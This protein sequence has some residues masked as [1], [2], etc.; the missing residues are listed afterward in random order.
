MKTPQVYTLKIEK[1]V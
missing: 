1:G